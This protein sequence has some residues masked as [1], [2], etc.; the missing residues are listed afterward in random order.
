M[1]CYLSSSFRISNFGEV[2]T[3]TTEMFDDWRYVSSSRMFKRTSTRTV[4][5]KPLQSR[6]IY[7]SCHDFSQL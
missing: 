2:K 5:T 7:S 3:G 6:K 1:K 4:E